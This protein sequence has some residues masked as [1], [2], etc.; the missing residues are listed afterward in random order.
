MTEEKAP[1]RVNLGYA[2]AQLQKAL[3]AAGGSTSERI[4]K[5]QSVIKG[6]LEGSLR[7]GSRTPV[8]GT[9]PWVTLDVI[10]G[11]FAT[12]GYAAGGPLRAHESQ[13]LARLGV[14]EPGTERS[15]LNLYFAGDD[16]RA[17]L[18]A[19]LE[20][21]TFRVEVPEEAALLVASWL[22]EEKE[23]IRAGALLESIMPWFAQLRFYPVPHRV[24]MRSG[25][26]VSV[27]TV[28]D[29]RASL[30]KVKPQHSVPAMRE[31]ILVWTPL[32]DRA[33][34]LF[35]ETVEGDVPIMRRDSDGEL[36]RGEGGQPVVE[37][38]WPCRRY[39]GDW[40]ERAGQLLAACV[41]AR[42]LHQL[43]GKPDK[44]KE[45]LARLRKYLDACVSDPVAMTGRD[46]GMV[47]KILASYVAKHG[48]PD[49]ERLRR[50]RSAQATNAATPAYGDIAR[51]V[52]ERLD[53][54]PADEGVSDVNPLVAPLTG[55][56]AARLGTLSAVSLPRSIEAKARRCLEAPVDQLVRSGLIPSSEV[57]AWV[58][59][60]LTARVR[61]EAVADPRLRRIYEGSYLAFRRRRSLL[62]LDLESQVKFNELPWVT[63]IEPWVGS[64]DATRDAARQTFV[65]AAGLALQ[66]FPQSIFPNRLVKE[67][68]A[69]ARTAALDIPLVDELAADI[70]MGAFSGVFLKAAQVAGRLLRTSLYERYYGLDFARV[71]AIDD[72]NKDRWG[73]ETSSAFAVMCQDLA[74]E[75]GERKWS[76][77]RNGTIIEQEQ[78]LTTHN[79]ACTWL[80]ADLRNQLSPHLPDLAL[81]CFA[82]VC[83]RQQI[84]V[85]HWQAKLQAIKNSAYAWRQ[86]LFFL[87]VMEESR[88]REAQ[89]R[90][91]QHFSTQSPAF[92]E[93]FGPAVRGLDVVMMGD[94]FAGD[95]H[96]PGSGG[97]RFLGW[98]SG[99]H[100][101]MPAA[102][103]G[104]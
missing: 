41:E 24:P 54:Y 72:L 63:A 5:W 4:E 40:R 43:C 65:A 49:S 39:P 36:V 53:H 82:W 47:R 98:T 32:Y 44:P 100:W 88:A 83:Q 11:G 74:G 64:D 60:A 58:L 19:M 70:F 17:D 90:I 94:G 78:I 87:S 9:P 62:L 97:R 59:P 10:H 22:L 71:L 67:L 73:K 16:G 86:M 56:E 23:A 102:R 92:Q 30:L 99:R 25:R 31:A 77:A 18:R 33:V 89:G 96:H 81:A 91:H 27:R 26:A 28:S 46:V 57:L 13:Q 61:A 8:A 15:V 50:T 38:G 34:A 84:V 66:S 52:A 21:G 1:I 14:A 69:L 45:N 75:P 93:L 42:R 104:E 48:A 35:M 29:T 76:V 20:T 95:G 7:V 37:G 55:P 2:V 51:L 103:E 6:L 85:L 68:R 12:G 3:A 101:L 79:L 80:D